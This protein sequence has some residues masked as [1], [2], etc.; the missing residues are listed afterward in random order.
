M[1]VSRPGDTLNNFYY[2]ITDR[3]SLAVPGEAA[4]LRR[5]RKVISW[6]VDF[7]QIR[8]KDLSDRRLFNLTR[9]VVEMAR[10]TPRAAPCRVLVNGRADI[11]AAAGADGVHLTSS[12][13]MISDIRAWIP[14]NFIVGVSVHATREIRAAC[15]GGVD[16]VLVGHVFPT[17]SK[18]GMGSALGVDFLRRACAGAPVSVLALGGITAERIPAVMQTGAAG[19]AGIGL[20]QNDNEFASLRRLAAK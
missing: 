1:R 18:E 19:V 12:G 6:G 8:E 5:V 2:Y 17:A 7:V 4:L 3:R 13:L 9:R 20:F 10:E 16:Y 11:A 15:A 14:K